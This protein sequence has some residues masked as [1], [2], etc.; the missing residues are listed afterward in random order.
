MRGFLES[1]RRIGPTRTA[2]TRPRLCTA[3]AA[4]A[5]VLCSFAV[6]PASGAP[7]APGGAPVAAT[8]IPTLPP[9][10]PLTA[11]AENASAPA[12]PSPTPVQPAV[13]TALPGPPSTAAP[14]PAPDGAPRTAEPSTPSESLGGLPSNIVLLVGVGLFVLV[15]TVV[16]VLAVILKKPGVIS[17]PSRSAAPPPP[18]PPIAGPAPTAWEGGNVARAGRPP[19][20]TLDVLP[21]RFLFEDG[22][23]KIEI[24]IFRTTPEDRVETT[25]GREEGPA[26]RHIQLLASTVSTRHAKLVFDRGSYSIIN[27][28]RLNPTKVNGE[29]LEENASRRLLDEDR[30][31]IGG[32]SITYSET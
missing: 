23:E 28:T 21:G 8:P 1:M 19:E 15:A 27:Y 31:E 13:A 32:I 2:G 16:V 6:L 25:I 7:Q 5:A 24:R 22:D 29:E 12:A 20:G 14:R 26:Y 30:L 18:P 4:V 3:F 11:P 10:P 9:L 17:V